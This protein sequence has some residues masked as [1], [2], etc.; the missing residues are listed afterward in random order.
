MGIDSGALQLRKISVEEL[1]N[2]KTLPYNLYNDFGDIVLSAGEAIT[3]GKLLKLR[4]ITTL[5][6]DDIETFDPNVER[7]EPALDE[8]LDLFPSGDIN[9]DELDIEAVKTRLDKER[10]FFTELEDE[11]EKEKKQFDDLY[12]DG[13]IENETNC[14]PIMFQKEAKSQFRKA[15]ELAQKRDSDKSRDIYQEIRDK[16]VEETLYV[17]DDVVY[18]SQLKIYGDYHYAHS[19]NVSILSTVLAYKLG[20]PESQIKDIALAAMVHDIGMIRIPKE[21]TD[22]PLPSTKETKII[23][24]HPQIGYRIIRKELGLPENIAVVA[25]EHHE[26]NDGSGYPYG[27][28]GDLISLASQIVMVCDVYD[29]ITSNRGPIKVKNSKE[30][31]KNMLDGGSKW[32][33]PKIL[34]TFVYM[35]N[36]NDT[37]PLM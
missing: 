7:T 29:T 31:I 36:Y 21:I 34:Y 37:L 15:F 3:P 20:L 33:T 26:R 23:Q 28:S 17:V 32:F 4:Y 35:S 11:K 25:L 8:E 24:L 30:A 13:Y 5:Y 22:K 27:I 14:L 1:T 9:T 12:D 16:I 10:A 19:L 6:T 18:K 2:F